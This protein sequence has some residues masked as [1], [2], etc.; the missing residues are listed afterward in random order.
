MFLFLMITDTVLNARGHLSV[1]CLR[2]VLVARSENRS[3]I[4]SLFQTSW[5]CQNDKSVSNCRVEELKMIIVLWHWGWWWF[6]G[7]NRGDERY[8]SNMIISSR[9]TLCP[10]II[11][12]WWFPYNSLYLVFFL[13]ISSTITGQFH[14]L[15]RTHLVKL[16]IFCRLSHVWLDHSSYNII[17]LNTCTVNTNDSVHATLTDQLIDKWSPNIRSIT[18]C[19]ISEYLNDISTPRILSVFALISCFCWFL[20]QLHVTT[21]IFHVWTNNS[22]CFTTFLLLCS[23]LD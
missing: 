18:N 12:T 23:S 13:K 10:H 15:R 1:E 7:S 4:E 8:A 2:T 21:N 16:V 17:Q 9:D 11:Q 14:H 19:S 5:Y 20:Q 22:I 6:W 3:K